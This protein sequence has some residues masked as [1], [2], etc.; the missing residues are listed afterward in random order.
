M[1]KLLET[2][3]CLDGKI[4]HLS[5]HQKR[6]DNSRKKLGFTDI[7][8]L[9][10]TPPKQGL[11]RCRVIY[12]KTIEDIEYIPYTIKD[13]KCFKLVHSDIV[14]DL[15]LEN[16]E[17]LNALRFE[18]ADE[19]IIIKNE[20]ITDTSIANICFFDGKLWLTPS[21]PLLKGTTRQRLL[22]EHK[23]VEADI[24]CKEIHKFSK[25]ALMNAMIGF[26]IIENAIIS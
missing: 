8:K 18:D 11:F 20:L 21:K 19:I 16:R 14:Y 4:F 13:I 3:K 23:I 1:P 2:I 10:L 12:E 15:K 25:I 9:Q 17:E 5:Y 22:E 7:L 24:S 26:H 6:L